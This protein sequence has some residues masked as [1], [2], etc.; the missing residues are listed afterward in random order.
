MEQQSISIAKAGIVC[1]LP[2]QTTILAAAN[3]AGGHYNKGKTIAENLKIS[4][5]MLSR[6][7]LIFIM[8]DQTN[9]VS[10]DTH[11]TFHYS[12]C[13]RFKYVV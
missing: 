12:K 9:E 1:N 3:P 10:F 11:D 4:S 13:S 7:D 2:T 5:P 6:F 8:L